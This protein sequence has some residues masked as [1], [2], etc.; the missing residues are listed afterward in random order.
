MNTSTSALALLAPAGPHIL[1]ARDAA[2]YIGKSEITVRQWRSRGMGP[3]Y[4]RQGRSISY[5]KSDLDQY[6]EEHRCGG[7]A[8]KAQP[9]PQP[10]L[11]RSRRQMKPPTRKNRRRPKR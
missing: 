11:P 6:L 2:R 3:P 7:S 10:Q 1:S 5:L 8:P 9:E 4:I